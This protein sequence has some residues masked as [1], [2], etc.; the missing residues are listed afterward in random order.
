MIYSY[1]AYYS[2]TYFHPNYC[3]SGHERLYILEVIFK[4]PCPWRSSVDGDV[5]I[6]SCRPWGE[7][8]SRVLIRVGGSI[9][10]LKLRSSGASLGVTYRLR[11]G[12]MLVFIRSRACPCR[13]AGLRDAHILYTKIDAGYIKMRIACEDRN[14]IAKILSNMKSSGIKLVYARWRKV[15]EGD[16]LTRRQEEALIMGLV[17][18][19]FDTPRRADLGD[20]S[21]DLGIAKPTAYTII[22][23]AIK[24]LI[25][26]H[27]L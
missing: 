21:R 23:K 26:H 27:L 5:R 9:D 25:R 3:V 15:K 11:D 13:L 8:G 20:L 17:K 18:G 12:T 24:K 4:I 2:S 16:F 19:F 10:P 22:K 7:N 1:I 14:E 6:L